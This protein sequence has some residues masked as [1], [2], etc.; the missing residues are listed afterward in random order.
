MAYSHTIKKLIEF[1]ETDMAGIVH[2]SNFFRYMEMAEH[3]FLRSLGLSVHYN[4]AGQ[5]N[6][7]ARV[8]AE[9]DYWSP[10]H[11]EEEVEIQLFV[12]EIR[13]KTINYFYV[14]QKLDTEGATIVATGTIIA[15]S[16]VINRQ[17][18]SI[19]GQEVPTNFKDVINICPSEYYQKYLKKR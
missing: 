12:R 2:F 9:C 17:D 1:S 7:W 8:H 10:L 11:F 19:R 4:E 16:V 5:C 18:N 14:F 6:G 13:H 3:S 15:V